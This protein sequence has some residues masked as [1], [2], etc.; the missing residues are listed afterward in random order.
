MTLRC[1]RCGRMIGEARDRF[2]MDELRTI[3][4]EECH[5]ISPP[6]G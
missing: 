6:R 3:H 1:S 2:E 5:P 4:G